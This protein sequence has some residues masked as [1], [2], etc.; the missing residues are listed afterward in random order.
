MGVPK[1]QD[2]FSITEITSNPHCKIKFFYQTILFFPHKMSNILLWV[3]LKEI[4]LHYLII[5]PKVSTVVIMVARVFYTE[6]HLYVVSP[7]GY[8]YYAVTLT[9]YLRHICSSRLFQSLWSHYTI[10]C[11]RSHEYCVL[12]RRDHI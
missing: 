3:I 7:Y 1:E 5:V 10:F 9:T 6:T 12:I 2:F 11:G 4:S 8:Y